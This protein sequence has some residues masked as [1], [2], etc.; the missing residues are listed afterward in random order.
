PCSLVE[1]T[2][3]AGFWVHRAASRPVAMSCMRVKMVTLRAGVQ[4]FRG[5]CKTYRVV[6]GQ[7]ARSLPPVSAGTRVGGQVM[8]VPGGTGPSYPGGYSPRP[9]IRFDAIGEAGRLFQQQMSTWIV[10]TVVAFIGI[11]IVFGV[12][13]AIM[14]A[15]MFGA[16][17]MGRG[18]APAFGI[19]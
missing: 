10:A 5:T 6:S 9:Q 16:M 3:P 14:G 19:G 8:A 2:T 1:F 15:M 13:Y 17:S 11:A 4:E 12:M 7:R 18:A